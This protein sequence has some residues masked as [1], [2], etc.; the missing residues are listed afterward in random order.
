MSTA[1]VLREILEIAQQGTSTFPQAFEEFEQIAHKAQA[2]LIK[3]Q[4]AGKKAYQTNLP[5]NRLRRDINNSKQAIKK[6]FPFEASR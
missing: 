6:T 3:N 4:E 5:V 1:K 2:L